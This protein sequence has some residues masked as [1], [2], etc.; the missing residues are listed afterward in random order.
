MPI[1][2]KRSRKKMSGGACTGYSMVASDIPG[3]MIPK[4]QGTCNKV[5]QYGGRK[6]NKSN[7][8]TKNNNKLTKIKE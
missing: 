3:V 5:G 8:N 7:S 4:S 1:S 2:K 6:K